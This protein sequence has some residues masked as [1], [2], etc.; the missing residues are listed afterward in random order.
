MGL[1]WLKLTIY[2]Y[3]IYVKASKGPGLLQ[4]PG[5]PG[6]KRAGQKTGSLYPLLPDCIGQQ[7]AKCILL[8][9]AAYYGLD[10]TARTFIPV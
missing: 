1:K 9:S 4:P 7:P 8:K 5:E 2:T 3:W 6:T 10:V